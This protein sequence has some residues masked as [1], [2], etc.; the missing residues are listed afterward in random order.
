MSWVNSSWTTTPVMIRADSF[1][2]GCVEP[3]LITS[4]KVCCPDNSASISANSVDVRL[5]WFFMLISVYTNADVNLDH[6]VCCLDLFARLPYTVG[7]RRPEWRNG[8][9]RQQNNNVP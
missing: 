1:P 4:A 9:R 7:S 5:A 3:H 2:A 6:E 8:G